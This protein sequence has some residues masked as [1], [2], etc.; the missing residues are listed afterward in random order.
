MTSL[1]KSDKQYVEKRVAE[2]AQGLMENI[3]MS[4]RESGENEPTQDQLD[5]EIKWQLIRYFQNLERRCMGSEYDGDAYTRKVAAKAAYAV[6]YSKS[7]F[8]P[9]KPSIPR[10]E[11]KG[12]L[13][14][15]GWLLR[16]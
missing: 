13:P 4:Y 1:T 15:S 6:E 11:Q 9:P 2:K 10:S 5:R 12:R 7:R 16:D 3:L 14:D 8:L